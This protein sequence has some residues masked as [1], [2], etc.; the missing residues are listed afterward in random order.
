M[1]KKYKLMLLALA[2]C[3]GGMSAQTLVQARKWFTDGEFEKAKPVFQRLVKQAP[4]NANYNFWYGACCYETGEINEA[5]PYLE[6]SAQRKVVDGFL[7]LSR[8]YYDLYRFDDAIT[9]LEDHIYWLERKKRDT[10]VADSLMTKYRLGARMIRGVEKVTVIDSFVVDKKEFLS[11][12][13]LSKESGEIIPTMTNS[14]ACIR[15]VNEMGDRMVEAIPDAEGETKLYSSV[16]LTDEWGKPRSLEDLNGSGQNLNYPFMDSDGITLYYAA[17]GEGSIGGYDIFVTRYNS[18]NNT[19]FRPDNIGMPFNSPFNDYMYAIDDFNN[20]GWFASDRWQPEGKVCVYVFIPNETKNVYDYETTEPETLTEL[21]MLKGIQKTWSDTGKVRIAK[22]QLAQ[23]MYG[24]E[25]EKQ[26]HDFN[27]IISDNA[28]YHFLSDFRSAEAR[29]M[30]QTLQQKEKD[31][32]TLSQSL[33]QLRSQYASAA[34]SGKEQ[35]APGILDKEKRVEELYKE[36]ESLGTDI[37]NT[38]I[39]SLTH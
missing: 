22:Q 15:F 37:R 8:A 35:M 2:C 30:Y 20:L 17:Q 6:K 29:K 9:N 23:I 27:F 24:G 21:A 34:Q 38:E 31:L 14:T 10:S 5:L 33:E 13:K 25:E 11:A 28:V 39:K 7:Y 3:A 32:T 12:Y 16:K 4:S 1:D 19:Y 36:I 26:R 18:D